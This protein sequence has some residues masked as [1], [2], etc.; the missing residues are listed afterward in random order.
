MMVSQIYRYNGGAEYIKLHKSG[1]RRIS[2][3]EKKDSQ[4]APRNG[5]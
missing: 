2:A 5:T 4:E 1:K 3:R